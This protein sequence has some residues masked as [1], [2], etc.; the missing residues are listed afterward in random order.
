M[1]VGD[2][3]RWLSMDAE[4]MVCTRSCGG[5]SYWRPLSLP[6]R[7]KRASVRRVSFVCRQSVRKPPTQKKKP[8]FSNPAAARKTLV[9]RSAERPKKTPNVLPRNADTTAWCDN[10]R[11]TKPCAPHVSTPTSG[12]DME[13]RDLPIVDPS[14]TGNRT[15][16]VAS[17]TKASGV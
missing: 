8:H 13:P 4:T 1:S 3:R 12:G 15:G 2:R 14:P 11:S 9:K 10:S 7:P 16:I 17:Q 5:G 6:T